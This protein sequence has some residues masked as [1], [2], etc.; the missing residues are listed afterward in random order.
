MSNQVIVF[1]D[2]QNLAATACE[3][4]PRTAGVRPF[5]HID[6]LRLGELL[7]SRRRMPSELAG[8]RVYRGRPN[9]R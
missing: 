2:Y 5:T 3:C 7:V 6:P 1:I 4:F 9:P 8:V